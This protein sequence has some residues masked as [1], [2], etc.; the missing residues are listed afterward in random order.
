MKKKDKK[1]D[2]SHLDTADKTVLIHMLQEQNNLLIEKYTKLELKYKLLSDRQSKDSTNSSKPP[3][4]DNNKA[5]EKRK[6]TTSSR[7]KSGKKAGGQPGHKGAHLKMSETPD[8]IVRLEVK[9]CVNCNHKLKA[10]AC[11]IEK[12]Q[13]FEIPE[14]KM[15]VTEYQSEVKECKK[16]GCVSEACFPEN[17]THI[18]QYGAR[19]KSLM[20]Y[21]NEYQLIPYAR[22]SEFFE[23]VYGH[24]ISPG[25]IVNAV[26]SLSLRLENVN[27]DIKQLLTKSPIAHTDETG[28]NIY[29]SKNWLH[30]VGNEE[31]THYE[32]HEKRGRQATIDIGIL[33]EFKGIMVHDHWKSYFT[34]KQCSHALCNAHHLRELRYINE[35]HNM[36]W[37]NEMS[38]LL[39]NINNQKDKLLVK[40]KIAFSKARLKEHNKIYDN[41]LRKAQREQAIRGTLDSKNLLKRLKNFK[42]EVLLFMNDFKVPFTNNLSERDL[43]MSKVKQKIS[44]CYRS[45]EGA[46]NYCKIRSVISTASKNK[47]NIFQ[48]LQDC[49]MKIIS[50]DDLLLE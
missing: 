25:T 47:R 38:E 30:T 4:S 27:N 12:R 19:A 45:D 15:W 13:Q 21:M 44:G 24:K 33:P 16:C 46:V 22:A 23:T 37:A 2:V 42:A 26:K 3:S 8:E 48:V 31:L 18:T 10:K 32:I 20:V 5:K 1:T 43:R 34:Y 29:G 28:I 49:F 40:N 39:I 9:K 7:K 11:S 50:I 35:Q 6:K 14:P 17:I 36:K 41:I